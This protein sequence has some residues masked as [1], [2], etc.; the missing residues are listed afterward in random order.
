MQE[1]IKKWKEANIHHARFE[2]S[3]GGD[4]MND[5]ALSFHNESGDT[6]EDESGVLE[7]YFENEVYNRVNFYEASDGHYIGES[8]CVVIELSDE[9][10]D[11][12]Y[13]KQAEAEWSESKGGEILVPITD[14]EF[15]VLDKYILG[16][17]NSSWNGA[18]VDYKQDFILTDEIEEVVKNLQEKFE[19]A[20]YEFEPETN[21]EVEDESHR[22]N[23]TTEDTLEMEFVMVDG[24]RNIKLLVECNCIEYT[25]SDD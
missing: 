12:F 10:D 11:F 20:S 24:V 13:N 15:N 3:C 7:N 23:T 21:G 9:D 18:N 2:F 22:Y 6:I 19:N 25:D 4:S 8:G 16:M 1:V 14:E 5:T 17:S